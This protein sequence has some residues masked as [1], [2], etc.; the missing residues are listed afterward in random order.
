MKQGGESSDSFCEA[1]P[2]KCVC[3][4][5]AFISFLDTVG[6]PPFSGV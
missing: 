6:K 3:Q 4:L 5:E 2:Y 1:L